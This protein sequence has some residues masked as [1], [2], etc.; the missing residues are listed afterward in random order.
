MDD[1][2]LDHL[3]GQGKLAYHRITQHALAVAY[4]GCAAATLFFQQCYYSAFD[5]HPELV[6]E[7]LNGPS[8]DRYRGIEKEI[9]GANALVL[10]NGWN[11]SFRKDYDS[12]QVALRKAQVNGYGGSIIYSWFRKKADAEFYRKDGEYPKDKRASGAHILAY[13][14][15]PLSKNKIII[16]DPQQQN[17]IEDFE[18]PGGVA[19][20]AEKSYEKGTFYKLDCIKDVWKEGPFNHLLNRRGGDFDAASMRDSMDHVVLDYIT[21]IG[22]PEDRSGI[23]LNPVSFYTASSKQRKLHYEPPKPTKIKPDADGEVELVGSVEWIKEYRES[24]KEIAK[25]LQDLKTSRPYGIKGRTWPDEEIAEFRAKQKEL[26]EEREEHELDGP[27]VL[28]RKRTLQEEPKVKE[29]PIEPDPEVEEVVPEAKKA[30]KR[31][32]RRFSDKPLKPEEVGRGRGSG[33]SPF[34]PLGEKVANYALSEDDIRGVVGNIPI[35]R[36]P[37]L[38]DMKTP[39][40]MFKGHKAAVLL[41]LTDDQDTGHWLT[42][43][44]RPDH[45]EVFDSYGVGA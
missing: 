32:L 3:R 41:F 28:K 37:E 14:T 20:A 35:Y 45:Y 17:A 43:L 12:C 13:V 40:E 1:E 8:P 26:R 6:R 10:F 36:Y 5:R 29:V 44:D 23:P 7:I 39:E 4:G 24:P 21:S 30:K 18:K 2:F 9:F 19:I 27:V 22:I 25:S 38:D 42:V 16:F 15:D 34:S 31:K 33:P 11:H